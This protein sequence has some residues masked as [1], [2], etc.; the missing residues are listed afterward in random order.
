MEGQL[1][2]FLVGD[3][4]LIEGAIEGRAEGF[5]GSRLGTIDGLIVVG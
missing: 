4:G 2:G 3:K 5:D 1:D